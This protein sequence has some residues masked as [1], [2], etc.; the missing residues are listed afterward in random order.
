MFEIIFFFFFND[1]LLCLYFLLVASKYR[2]LNNFFFLFVKFA[3]EN[4][5]YMVEKDNCFSFKII[6]FSLVLF[7]LN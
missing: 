5:K 4:E 1:L 3:K 6:I 2:N 7:F